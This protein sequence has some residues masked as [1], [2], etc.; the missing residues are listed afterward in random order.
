MIRVRVCVCVHA[1]TRTHTLTH[2]TL[3]IV[4]LR[5]SV[6][7]SSVAFS[8]VTSCLVKMMFDDVGQPQPHNERSSSQAQEQSPY[9]RRAVVSGADWAYETCGGR[10]T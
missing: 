10:L 3:Y 1:R 6:L 2:K 4:F 9:S 8:H 5:W 7:N